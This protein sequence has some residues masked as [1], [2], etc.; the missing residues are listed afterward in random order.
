MFFKEMSEFY[1]KLNANQE[2]Y[3]K[4]VHPRIVEGMEELYQSEPLAST[5]RAK[6]RLYSLVAEHFEPV[7]FINSPFFYEMGL[8]DSNNWGAGSR[9]VHWLETAERKKAFSKSEFARAWNDFDSLRAQIGGNWH[10]NPGLYRTPTPGFDTD[11]NSIGYSLLFKTGISGVLRKIQ[12]KYADFE[13]ESE[14]CS[15][16]LACEEG[17]RALIKVANKFANEAKS[18]LAICETDT[19]RKYMNM[20]ADAAMYVPENP[21]RSFYEGLAM[22]WFL[23]EAIGSFESIGISVLGQVDLLLGELYERDIAENRITENDARELI[24]LWLMPT[25]IKFSSTESAWPETSTCITLGGCDNKGKPIYNEVTRLIIETHCDMKLVA[26][27]LNLRYSKEAPEEY[28][29]LV[30]K[31]IIEG[32]NVFALSCDDAV[33]PS[34]EKCGIETIDARRYVNGGC[35]ETIVEGAGHTAGAYLYVLL[36]AILDMSLNTSDAAESLGEETQTGLPDRITDAPDFEEFYSAFLANVKKVIQKASE[37]QIIMGTEQKNINPC[38]LFSA[39][40]AGCIENGKDYTAGGAKYNL[41]TICM[42]GIATLTDAM[43]AIKTMVYDRRV[44]TL[45][46]MAE[47]LLKNW[48]NEEELRRTCLKLPK[49]GCG[50]MDVDAIAKRLVRDMNVF[51]TEIPNERGGKNIMSMFTYYLFKTFAPY[52]RATADGRFDGEY[53]SQGIAAGRAQRDTN[54]VTLLNTVK[55]VEYTTISGISVLDVVLAPGIDEQRLSA[56]MRASGECGC[57]NLQIN[58]LSPE[59]LRDARAHPEAHQNLI[60]R[61]AGLSVYFVNLEESIQDEIIGRSVQK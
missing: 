22:I 12:E 52:I 27:K 54:V 21:P 39:T 8:R 20:I 16:L 31:K 49:Y 50:N 11:H 13:E 26:P 56:L 35:Q 24:R 6:G 30:S 4:V 23:R 45:G 15:F 59:E 32:S 9:P 36:P 2:H 55:N 7:V 47:V 5:V 46:Q 48:E 44:L 42:C 34:L 3:Y 43:F 41:S 18:A 51:I 1:H 57:P 53:L 29:R 10:N 33:I 58:F 61:V 38:P 60:V 40:H 19:Q 25:D 17:C 28:L 14:E 37:R